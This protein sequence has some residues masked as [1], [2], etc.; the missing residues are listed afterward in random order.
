MAVS[1]IKYAF[2][3]LCERYVPAILQITSTLILTRMILPSEFGEVALITVIVEMFT[4]IISSG[5]SE[6][7]IYNNTHNTKTLYSTVFFVNI[8]VAI[9]LYSIL[10]F[11]SGII[12]S[13]YGIP[14][15]KILIYVVGLNLIAYAFTYIHRVIYI[16]NLDFKT[17]A[18]ITFISTIAGCLSL[19]SV[20]SIR[21][22][23]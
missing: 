13:F 11:S 3:S 9:L 7:L 20:D 8:G 10:I 23:V 5:L 14:R 12:A 4:L 1:T 15:L 17:P 21:A 19:N 16:I 6:G 2:W 22:V 18:K